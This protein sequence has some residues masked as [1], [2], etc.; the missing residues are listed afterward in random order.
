MPLVNIDKTHR[1]GRI[2][3]QSDYFIMINFGDL[4]STFLSKMCQVMPRKYQQNNGYKRC[5]Q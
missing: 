4:I 2:K 1:G 5:R 3:V